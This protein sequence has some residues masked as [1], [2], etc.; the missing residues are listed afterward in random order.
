M[1][2]PTHGIQDPAQTNMPPNQRQT[3]V[4]ETALWLPRGK[5]VGKGGTEA[6]HQQR[7][8]SLYRILPTQQDPTVQ[9]REAHAAPM[10]NH[11]GKEHEKNTYVTKP[12]CYRAE[13]KTL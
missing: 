12:L 5:R 11:N 6:W 4:V 2:S 8:T 1:L 7:R 3:Q 10:R 9:H 13:I